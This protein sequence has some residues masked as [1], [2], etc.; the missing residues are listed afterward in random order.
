MKLIEQIKWVL[1]FI[2][3]NNS[4]D[5]CLPE[6]MTNECMKCKKSLGTYV[7]YSGNEYVMCK[8]CAEIN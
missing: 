4:D 8:K 3:Y 7:K 2:I 5:L 6:H 1:S